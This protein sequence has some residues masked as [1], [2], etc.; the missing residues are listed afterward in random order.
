MHSV[1]RVNVYMGILVTLVPDGSAWRDQE[2]LISWEFH[3]R[4]SL[5]RTV[6]GEQ[7]GI[8]WSVCR[9]EGTEEICSNSHSAQQWWAEKHLRR[10]N[11]LNFSYLSFRQS[12]TGAQWTY[13]NR[14]TWLATW[15]INIFYK[16]MTLCAI[17]KWEMLI[18]TVELSLCFVTV[19]NEPLITISMTSCCSEKLLKMRLF[20]F[21]GTSHPIQLFQLYY[22]SLELQLNKYYT[23]F[24]QEDNL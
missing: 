18:G 15:M 2:L 16:E 4:Q 1:I 24:G 5:Y 12:R 14:A 13:S 7:S 9:W 8:E 3:A 6:T 19:P 21:L 20:L 22:K 10:H 11:T 23:F 17:R